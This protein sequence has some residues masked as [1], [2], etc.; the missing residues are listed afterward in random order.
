MSETKKAAV[1]LLV[2]AVVFI[3][4]AFS[5]AEAQNI[6]FNINK[7][8]IRADQESKVDELVAYLNKYPNAK[9]VI[10]GYADKKTGNARINDR[11]SKQR[12]AAVSEALQ[13][14]GIAASRIVTDAKGDTVQPFSVNEE[15]RVSICIAE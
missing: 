7:S 3:L 12:S 15:N 11:L 8:V 4:T 6:F 2:A 10:T 5:S 14:K 1:S 9:V 13:A